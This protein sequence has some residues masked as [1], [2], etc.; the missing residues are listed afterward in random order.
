MFW[1]TTTEAGP[2]LVRVSVAAVV[3]TAPTVNVAVPVPVPGVAL[4]ALDVTVAELVTAVLA[5]AVEA[6]AVS[7]MVSVPPAAIAPRVPVT[8]PFEF[9]NVLPV[10]PVADRNVIPDGKVSVKV[11][12]GAAFVVLVF[13]TVMVQLNDWPG[14]G[15]VA[16]A[17]LVTVKLGA[18]VAAALTVPV[19]LPLAVEA[20]VLVA[21]GA[22][23]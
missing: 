6:T 18:V 16:G 13:V 17:V 4:P 23:V 7:V 19:K 12:S 5:S 11:A 10:G 2:V 21:V 1:P 15:A 22:F 14:T 8:T 20:F 9:V 3:G